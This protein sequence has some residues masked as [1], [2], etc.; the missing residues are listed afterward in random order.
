MKIPMLSDAMVRERQNVTQTKKK[1]YG[2][3]INFT[4]LFRVIN[5]RRIE[6]EN[7]LPVDDVITT[8]STIE[9]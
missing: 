7:I 9:F 3:Y 2:R 8:G 1:R 6:G 4:E 5:P